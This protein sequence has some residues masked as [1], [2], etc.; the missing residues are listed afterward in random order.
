VSTLP[1]ATV[2][3]FLHNLEIKWDYKKRLDN[4][5][6]RKQIIKHARYQAMAQYSSRVGRKRHVQQYTVKLV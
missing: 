5:V 1:H 6:V 3:I 4:F 2:H